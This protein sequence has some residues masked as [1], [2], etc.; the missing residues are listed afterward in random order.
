MDPT[1]LVCSTVVSFFHLRD[2]VIFHPS[3]TVNFI[4][5]R[6]RAQVIQHTSFFGGMYM[7]DWACFDK[8]SQVDFDLASI[9]FTMA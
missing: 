1:I 4:R 9:Q 2:F 7:T 5:Q 8:P 3:S 6:V